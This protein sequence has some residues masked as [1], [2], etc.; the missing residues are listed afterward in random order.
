MKTAREGL[1]HKVASLQYENKA[2]RHEMEAFRTGK[3]YKKM[4]EDYHRIIA[5]YVKEINKLKKELADAHVRTV[6]V[7]EI[8]FEE[9][10]EGWEQNQSVLKKKDIEIERLESE[11]WWLF[12]ETYERDARTRAAYEEKLSEKDTVIEALKAELAYAQALLGRDSTNTG[13]PTK[14]DPAR[15]EETHTQYPPQHR[16][17]KGRAAGT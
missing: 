7:R 12:K 2:L 13:T 10:C 16:E 17:S 8:W 4:Q 15:E 5:G 9:C 1:F 14:A 3:K 6:S 11:K